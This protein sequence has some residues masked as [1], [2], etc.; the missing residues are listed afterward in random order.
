MDVRFYDTVAGQEPA[1]DYLR[2]LDEKQRL[3]VGARIR[4]IQDDP[5]ITNLRV[6]GYDVEIIGGSLW[7]L[8]IGYHRIFYTVI[9]EAGAPVMWLLHAAQKDTNK[10][11]ALDKAAAYGRLA[12]LKARLARR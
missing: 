5:T 11:P 10:T 1:R 2:S 4:R 9:H 6:A 7:E 3:L 12:D 8:R